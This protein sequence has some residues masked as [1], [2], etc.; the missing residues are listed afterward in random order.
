[1]SAFVIMAIFFSWVRVTRSLALYICFVDCCLSFCTFSLGHC[2]VCSALIY[3]LP[4]YQFYVH[5]IN[6]LSCLSPLV[7]LFP[8][9]FKLFGF[10]NLLTM[11]LLDEGYSRNI[12]ALIYGLPL[13]Y[14]Q[15]LLTNIFNIRAKYIKWYHRKNC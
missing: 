3:G 11:S 10:S 9:T 15:T 14:L 12:S 5:Y 8:K 2:V 1:M 13:C 6:S 7:Y 4:L